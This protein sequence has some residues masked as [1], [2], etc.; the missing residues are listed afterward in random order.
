MPER[1]TEFAAE[2]RRLR[3]ARGLSVRD[4]AG[5]TFFSKSYIGM[6]EHGDRPPTVHVARR[7]DDALEANG[8]LVQLADAGRPAGSGAETT[9]GQSRTDLDA[10]MDA[11]D[12]QHLHETVHHLVGL[13]TAHGSSGLYHS[14][15]RAFET[16]QARLGR[17]GTR[18]QDR[19]DVHAAL[20]E[21]GEVA[22]WLA[23]DS[24]HQDESRRVATE[25]MIVAQTVGDT[26]MERFIVSHLSMQATYLGRGAEGLALADRVIAERPRSKRVV[27]LMRVRRA[28]ALAR[29]GD[30]RRALA[31]FEIARRE[32]AGG[33]G[34]DDPAWSWWL[35]N[36]EMAVHESRIRSLSGDLTGAA[37]WSER[38][39]LALP[40]KQ[41]RDQA[42]YRAWLISDLVDVGAW[43]EADEVIEQLLG[44][45]PVG[46]SARVPAILGRTERRA[47]RAAAPAWFRDSLHEAIGQSTRAA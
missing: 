25:A 5:R 31:E 46:S 40:A 4:L 45:I 8:A 7:L 35:H 15:I 43:R 14:A 19:A 11:D 30:G 22:A 39:V 28:R 33:I 21:V 12:V 47:G 44:K 37:A 29:I 10:P 1:T 23:Y 2:L 32:L 36:A 9:S 42:L 26:S 27:G 20:A 24:E 16:A 3:A 18:D 17:V 41:G 38:A 34:P 6:L 13:D